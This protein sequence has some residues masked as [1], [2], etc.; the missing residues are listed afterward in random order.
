MLEVLFDR[1][2]PWLFVGLGYWLVVQLIRQNGRILLRLEGM[3]EKL[4]S[5]E[6]ARA[7]APPAGLPVGSAAPA[8]ELPNLDGQRRSLEQ[9]RGRQV[10]LIFFTPGCGFC[11]KMAPELAAL[12]A[13]G[14]KDGPVPLVIATGDAAANRRLFEEHNVRCPVLLQETMEVAAQYQARGTPMGYLID[15]QGKIASDLTVGAPGLLALVQDPASAKRTESKEAQP[16][17]RDC[18]CGKASNDKGKA[19]KG[20]EASKLNRS[21]LK[22]G[23]PAPAFRLT[24]LDGAELALEDYRGRRVLLVFSDPDC[25]PCD[26]LAP[27]LQRL[28]RERDDLAVVMVSRRD[29]EANRRKVDALGLTFAVALQKNWEVSR[30]YA[31]FAT[32]VG[33]LIDEQGVIVADVATGV[34][35]I[36]ALASLTGAVP[37]P[38][39]SNGQTKAPLNGQAVAT[40][41]A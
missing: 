14:S 8:F 38:A 9:F 41:R 1:V 10:V 4:G 11:V 31:I 13:D 40:H 17:A 18:G 28:H 30:L 39:P 25:G 35:P 34:E 27:E 29:P 26:Q 20:L 2:L 15:E 5:P 37:V 23:T 33:Y 36:L 22:A 32:P 6:A 21:G 12:A 3:E 19:N 24:R 7:A 16:A